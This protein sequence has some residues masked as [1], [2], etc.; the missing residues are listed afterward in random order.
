MASGWS[1]T[2]FIK[3]G[4]SFKYVQKYLTESKEER[5]AAKVFGISKTFKNEREAAKFVDLKMIE[6]GKEPVNVLV[7]L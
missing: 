5:F 6:R 7:K 3:N 4:S 2:G 1:K